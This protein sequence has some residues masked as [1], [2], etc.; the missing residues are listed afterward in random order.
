MNKQIENIFKGKAMGHPVHIMLVHFP[1]AFFPM[2]AV[3]D[4]LSIIYSNSALSLFSF[5]SSS[6]GVILGTLAVIFGTIDLIKIPSK[7]K[8]FNI[9]LIH[10]GLNFL[11]V[12]IF[13][14]IA[15]INLKYYPEINIAGRTQTIIEFLSVAGMIYSNF[16]GGELVLKFGMGK[17]E[18]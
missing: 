17:K 13:A 1:V 6:A 7:E 8:H 12:I 16:L 5:Y 4:L 14:A 11:W 2:S 10:G 18:L 15:G 3:L 9:A